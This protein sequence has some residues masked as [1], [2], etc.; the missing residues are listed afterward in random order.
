MP[1]GIDPDPRLGWVYDDVHRGWHI[2][3]EDRFMTQIVDL[4]PDM[5]AEERIEALARVSIKD[6]A[7]LKR[8]LQASGRTWLVFHALDLVDAL[9]WPDGVDLF[10]QVVACYR[11]HRASL[12]TGRHETQESP[13]TGKE[14]QVSIFKGETLEVEEMIQAVR[15]LIGQIRGKDPTWT[16]EKLSM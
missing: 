6:K 15:A 9:S 8:W 13:V 11:E 4:H 12:E 2:P 14:V 1:M 3:R 16:P 7:H 5:S 10:M